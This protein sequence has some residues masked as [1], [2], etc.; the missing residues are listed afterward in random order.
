MRMCHFRDQNGPFVLNNFFLVQTII[1]FTYLLALFIVQNFKNSYCRSRVM[2]M[3]YIWAQNGP[4]AP[5]N[6]SKIIN[7]ILI[8]LLAPFTVQSF[9]KYL[10]ADPEL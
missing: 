8:Y 4:L 5:K 7:I 1:T 2:R 3:C 10:P 6:F 9:K